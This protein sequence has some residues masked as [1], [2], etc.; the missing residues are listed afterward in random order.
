MLSAILIGNNIVNIAASSITTIF[1]QQ[2][3]GSWAISI[4]SGVL[5]LLVLVFGEI[6]PKTAATG[7][8]DKFSLFVAKPIWFLTKVLTPIIVVINF[9]ASCIMKLFRININEK[10]STFTE[11]ELRTIMDVSH[12]EG[13]IEE[14]PAEEAESAATEAD[15]EG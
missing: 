7:Y 10:E 15:F 11:E 8:A 3:W 12:E 5:T 13:V 14:A 6:T 9:L 4:G 2:M 1:F